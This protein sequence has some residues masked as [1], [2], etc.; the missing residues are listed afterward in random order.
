V[1]RHAGHSVTY[2]WSTTDEDKPA[3]YWAAFYSDCEHE[4]L[5][6]T[7]GHRVTLTYNLFAVPH[8]TSLKGKTEG[9]DVTGLPL[10]RAVKEAL[11]EPEFLPHGA[12][13]QYVVFLRAEN[14]S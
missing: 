13:L 10:Y 11:D 2:D 14:T 4:V 8:R 6:V 7:T 5:E 9:L 1:V 12:L 3:I